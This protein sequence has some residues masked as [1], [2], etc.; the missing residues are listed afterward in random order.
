[1]FCLHLF[2]VVF[3][4]F[5]FVYVCLRLFTFVYVCL[6]TFFYKK[7][8]SLAI[9]FSGVLPRDGCK[10]PFSDPSGSQS[11]SGP[12][13][14]FRQPPPPVST[15]A[16]M[17]LSTRRKA[18]GNPNILPT[19]QDAGGFWS[20]VCGVNGS[21]TAAFPNETHSHLKLG[22]MLKRTFLSR[23]IKNQDVQGFLLAHFDPNSHVCK[24]KMMCEKQSMASDFW[25]HFVKHSS[26]WVT[27]ET[28]RRMKKKDFYLMARDRADQGLRAT[29]PDPFNRGLDASAPPPGFEEPNFITF[30]GLVKGMQHNDFISLRRKWIA[31]IS[32]MEEE[33][34]A[35]AKEEARERE[36][37]AEARE[38][39]RERAEAEARERERAEAE[40]RERSGRGLQRR[41]RGL[42]RRRRGSERRR[43]RGSEPRRRRGLQRGAGASG[44]GGAGASRGGGAGCRGGGAGASRGGGTRRSTRSASALPSNRSQSS[45]C[46]LGQAEKARPSP[47]SQK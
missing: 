26:E 37:E 36:R 39:E 3:S 11:L 34:E 7:T 15:I 31:K 2:I 17:C 41:R 46:T 16:R 29:D 18:F 22:W 38:Q 35:E 21:N 12:R 42:Q 40:A 30:D 8:H 43:R 32:S 25:H 14:P 6:H 44:G 5:T 24:Y 1:M 13:R 20:I 19:V 27:K 9:R 45:Q 4:L 23:V 28:N 33:A 47:T 10:R